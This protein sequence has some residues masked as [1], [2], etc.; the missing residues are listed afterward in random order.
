MIDP[1]IA[2]GVVGIL[3]TILLAV[4]GGL[5]GLVVQGLNKRI[6]DL[7][8]KVD[9]LVR[10]VSSLTGKLDACRFPARDP[11]LESGG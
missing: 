2:L 4:I 3:V 5:I 8:R 10:E 1:S 7:E 11:R 9:D 6:T